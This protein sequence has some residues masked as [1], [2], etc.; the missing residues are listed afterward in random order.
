MSNTSSEKP[1]ASTKQTDAPVKSAA[2]DPNPAE[3][4]VWP[5]RTYQDAGELKRRAG[6]SYTAPRRHAEALFQRGLVS[7]EEPKA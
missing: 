5:L 6:P 1:K 7:L 2:V 4:T 3:V